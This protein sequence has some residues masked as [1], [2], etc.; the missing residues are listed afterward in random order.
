MLV[1]KRETR[2]VK[3]GYCAG[4]ADMPHAGEV[5]CPDANITSL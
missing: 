4:Y 5:K 2:Y 1:D 3:R